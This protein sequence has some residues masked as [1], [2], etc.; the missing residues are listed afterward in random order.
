MIYFDNAATSYPKPQ[1]VEEAVISAMRRYGANPG[2]SG[3]AMSLSAAF[4][5]FECREKA[6]E[7]F[8]AASPE[9]VVFTQNCTHAL[10]LA[11]KGILRQ[12]DHVIISDLEHNSVLRPIHVMAERGIITY[13][14]AKIGGTDE[15]TLSEIATLIRPNTKLVACA[16][17]SN[18]WGIRTPIAAIGQLCRSKGILFLSDC[19]QTA[20]HVDIDVQRDGIDFL[21]CAG[22]KGLYGP[23]GTGLLITRHGESLATVIEGGTGTYSADYS[24]PGSMPEKLESGTVNTMG[25]LGLG[26]GISFIKR[27]G[28]SNIYDHETELC[29]YIRERLSRLDRVRLYTKGYERCGLLPVISFNIEGMSSEDVVSKL[30]EKGFALRGGLHCSPLAH[31]KMGTME[32]GAARISVGAFNNMQQA[33]QLC[34]AVERIC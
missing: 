21:C 28:I 4:K 14:V 13:S 7:M 19:A 34:N 29:A 6:A 12:G 27:R 24:Q 32:T 15:V 33:R 2:R 30:D 16:H 23:S 26:A 18:V 17:G 10:N 11:I 5:V 22:H 31:T 20:G 1:T 25:I 9:D 8:G 3:H